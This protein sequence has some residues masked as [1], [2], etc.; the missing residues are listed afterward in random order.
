MAVPAQGTIPALPQY[1][2]GALPISG[3]EIVE[4]ASSGNATT[5]AS[6]QMLITDLVGKA[7]SQMSGAVPVATDLL[8]FYQY[9]TG[10]PRVTQI[11]NL[12]ISFGNLPAGGT[13]G[14]IL[15]KNSSTNFDDSWI[16][17]ATLISAISATGLTTAGSTSV[18]IS[19]ANGGIGS[20]Q[21]ANGA[22][23]QA[24]IAAGAVGS[25]QIATSGVSAVNLAVAAV[26]LTSTAITGVL[27]VP[28]GGTGAT[29]LSPNGVLYGV[30]T[31]SVG[32]APAVTTAGWVLSSNGTANPP[33]FQ[34]VSLSGSTGILGVA[35][36]GT[37][38]STLTANAV[39]L[40]AAAS[41]LQF[42][43]VATAGR[44]LVDQG[45]GSNPAFQ[46]VSG[47]IGLTAAGTASI[48]TGAV[49][50]TQIATGGVVFSA[51]P[52]IASG[53]LLG[54]LSGSAGTIGTVAATT[55]WGIVGVTAT[56]FV[57][58][59][60]TAQPPFG[61]DSPINMGL[62]ATVSAGLLTVNI[63]AANGTFATAT[64]PILV[65]FRNA[66]LTAGTPSWA[67]IT[68]ALSISTFSTGATFGSTT[69]VPFRL[70]VVLFWQ[71]ATTV[72]PALI[73][74]SNTA[75]IFPLADNTL[76]NSVGVTATATLA[77]T[78]Y[79]PNGTTVVGAPFRIAGYVEYG[80]G[81]TSPGTYASA[82]TVIQ[83]FGPG[84][85]KPNDIVQ[86]V[87]V[88]NGAGSATTTTVLTPVANSNA[89][90]TPTSSV[91]QFSI[92]YC[93]LGSIS[94]VSGAGSNVSWSIARNNSTIGALF[95]MGDATIDVNATAP[96]NLT[97]VD[98]PHT[99][100]SVVYSLLQ[101]ASTALATC[102]SGN[103]FIVVNELMG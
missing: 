94:A 26:D 46:I 23:V 74:C 30:N 69:S 68:N 102:N 53:T 86:S 34:P 103:L 38:T 88:F 71:N 77:G 24:K 63:L 2:P 55:G 67:T 12:G 52:T 1:Q 97:M 17:L 8:A 29:A 95:S 36:G 39:L 44:I 11:G 20:T 35:Q 65:P 37:N 45:A 41:T 96:V 49:G 7:P 75:Q 101:A 89:T 43:T 31:A 80:S 25:T 83:L 10:L 92:G 32:I 57:P 76:Q 58:A 51:L 15:G 27:S 48:A 60:A 64:S 56:S 3:Q 40:G 16:D 18:V 82:P 90:V 72:M 73:N 59:I 78:F 6:Y 81:L 91:N 5:A 14:Q 47:A 87:N 50:S 79:T 84:S 33:S 99:T 28:L 85:K 70:W 22:V 54:N 13:A 100:S 66:N 93:F 21:L 4:I 62:G 19:I 61:F 42:A 98:Q 9:G